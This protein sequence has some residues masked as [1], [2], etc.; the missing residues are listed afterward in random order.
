MM[1]NKNLKGEQNEQGSWRRCLKLLGRYQRRFVA[2]LVVVGCGSDAVLDG[3]SDEPGVPA[4]ELG[5]LEQAL[6]GSRGA[7]DTL[8]FGSYNLEWFGDPNNGPSNDAVQ[9][10]NAYE[11]IAGAD[12]DIWGLAEIVSTSQFSQ[13][14][15]QLTGYAGLLAGDASVT[16]GPAYYG[17]SEQKVGILYKSAIASVTS[18]R[19]ILTGSDY[20]FAGRP[21]LEVRL[22]V[23]LNGRTEDIVVVVMHA[24]CCS[25]TTS[26]QRRQSASIAL[27]SY[28]DATYPTEKVWVIGDF[29][30]DLDTSISS[31]RATP[32]ANFVSDN[33]RYRFPTQALTSAG[34]STTLSYSDAIDHHLASNEAFANYVAGSV[35]AYRVDQQIANYSSSTSDHLPVL[36]RYRWN[37]GGAGS[38]G[39]GGAGGTGGTGGGGSGGSGSSPAQVVL[40][41]VCANEPGSDTAGEFVELLNLGGT[42]ADLSGWTL[43]DGSSVRHTFSTGTQLLPGR[44]LVVFGDAS[45]IP[46]GVSNAIGTSTGT[47]SF[48]NSGDTVSL[49]NA[50]GA[51]LQTLTYSSAQ[52]S[53]D[54]VSLNRGPDGSATGEFVKH[55]TLSTLQRSP[56]VRSSGSAW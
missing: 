39:A 10:Q 54:G 30:D 8:D 15:T 46:A 9:R 12:L 53:T 41:E 33:A 29:N 52:V 28:L 7:P 43:R 44:A 22:R 11:V 3:F 21:P 55:T 18:A 35:E 1:E 23:T 32:Y 42:A 19:I 2:G 5:A 20:E 14:K 56:G 40:N 24:K 37:S 47:L 45:G 13:L 49:R 36:S 17:G 50:A 51:T 48:G 4:S 38:G 27:K 16:N 31:G 6:V 34:I 25:D 26:W